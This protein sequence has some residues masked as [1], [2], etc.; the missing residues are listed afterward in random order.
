MGSNQ[1]LAF[2]YYEKESMLAKRNKIS[3]VEFRL[4][5]LTILF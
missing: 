3:E 1:F 5:A 4:C 2:K